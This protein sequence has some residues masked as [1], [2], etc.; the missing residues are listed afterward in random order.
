M[1]RVAIPG[2]PARTLVP[3]ETVPSNEVRPEPY[4]PRLPCA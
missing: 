4:S 2:K 3:G 1:T